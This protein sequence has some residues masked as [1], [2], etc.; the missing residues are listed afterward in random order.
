[1]DCVPAAVLDHLDAADPGGVLGV[2]LYGSAAST[3]L[4]PDSDIDL[5]VITACSLTD[6]E[7]RGLVAMLLGASGWSGHGESFPE[8]ADRRPVELTSIVRPETDSWASAL[9]IDFQYGEW[10]RTEIADGL[11]PAPTPDP[12]LIILAATAATHHRVLRGRPLAELLPPVPDDLLR[13]TA[14]DLAAVVAAGSAGDE[15]NALLT[16]ARIVVTAETG[17]IVSK[18][19]AAE[20]VV[21]LLPDHQRRL[22]VRA[23][24]E[25]LGQ[26]APGSRWAEAADEVDALAGVLVSRARSAVA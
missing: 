10:L 22:L 25:Y 7:R 8:A 13:R 3:G 12:D 24:E 14:A 11:L 23:R 17:R 1:M 6:P 15:C 19:A 18:D 21:R 26:G 4:R 5:L 20:A 2:Y 16:L 9:I